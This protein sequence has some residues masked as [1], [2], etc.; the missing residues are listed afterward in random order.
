MKIAI[1]FPKDS[2]ALFNSDSTRTFGGASVHVYN[3]AKQLSKFTEVKTFSL[4][5][6]YK[7]VSFK[8]ENHFNLVQFF[9]EKDTFIRKVLCLR[10]AIIELNPDVIIQHG[11]TLQSCLLSLYCRIKKIK[12]VF[13]FAHDL[14]SQGKYQR[15]GKKCRLIKILL[16]TAFLLITQNKFQRKNL[17]DRYQCDS[18]IIYYGC[19]IPPQNRNHREGV[20]WVARAE[21]WKQPELFIQLA[22]Q[23]MNINF[24]MIC[25][26]AADIH[27]YDMIKDLASSLENIKFIPYV[28]YPTI[29][30]YFAKTKL[31]INTSTYEGFPYTF[32]QAT[33]QGMPIL[34]LNVDS[35]DIIADHQCGKCFKG[36][37]DSLQKTLRAIINNEPLWE[38]YSN[39]AYSYATRHHN[40]ELNTKT[41]LALL[42]HHE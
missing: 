8:D 19:T 26:P 10:K 15:N 36:D 20:L 38:K 14:E 37:L 34:S 1:I 42:E 3:L 23:N 35:D 12:F 31:F 11:L 39:Q 16:K 6:K 18:T 40:L 32:I 13:W 21:K 17:L 41:L 9:E 5:P 30:D 4:I 24:T 28:S 7:T 22:R 2:E 27:Y 33:V 25:P 29:D